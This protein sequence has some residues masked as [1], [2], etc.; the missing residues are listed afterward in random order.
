MSDP[1]MMCTADG[2]GGDAA[3]AAAAEENAAAHTRY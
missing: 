2:D 3:A 1:H